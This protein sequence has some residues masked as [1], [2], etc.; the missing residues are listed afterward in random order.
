MWGNI[1]KCAACGGFVQ[2]AAQL[3]IFYINT[4]RDCAACAALEGESPSIK[5]VAALS[6][7]FFSILFYSL[8]QHKVAQL[9]KSFSHSGWRVCG[10][11]KIS[12]AM[13]NKAAHGDGG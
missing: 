10:F 13:P 7:S 8:K 2:E 11:L 6:P 3:F 12:H 4:L 5:K 1:W 9:K